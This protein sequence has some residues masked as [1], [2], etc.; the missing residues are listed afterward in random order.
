MSTTLDGLKLF[1]E[2]QLKIEIGSY[3]RDVIEKSS[4][5]LEGV[6]S[7]DLGRRSRKINQKGSLRAKSRNALNERIS[8]ISNLMDG[9]IHTLTSGS[10]QYQN[11]RFDSFKVI[12][13]R[14]DGT[15]LVADYEIIYTQLV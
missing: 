9:K 1:D 10:I 4:P 15:G 14:E 3:A 11:L 7:I 6:I 2:N 12:S 8:V 5:F 13:E